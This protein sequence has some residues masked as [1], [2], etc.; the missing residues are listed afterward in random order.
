L[1]DFDPAKDA[2]PYENLPELDRYMLHRMCEVF[3]EVK[4]AFDSFQFSRFFQTVLNFCTV[5]LS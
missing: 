1:H 2:V 4:D 3:A 5:D